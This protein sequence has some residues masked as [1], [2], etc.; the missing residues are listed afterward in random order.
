MSKTSA[1]DA[2]E[3]LK[4][5]RVRGSLVEWSRHNG[6]ESATSSLADF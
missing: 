1:D 2:R 4:R 3:L 5:R 6:L